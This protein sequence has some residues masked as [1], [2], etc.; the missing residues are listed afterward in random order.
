MEFLNFEPSE[1]IVLEES[2][3]FDET[4]QRP[5]KIRFFTLEEQEVDAYEKLLPKGKVTQFERNTLRDEMTRIHDLYTQFVVP[6]T[7]DYLLREPESSKHISWVYPVYAVDEYKT[8][9]FSSSWMPLYDNVRAP[10]FYSRMLT[11]LPSPFVESPEGI[12]TSVP[13]VTEFLNADGQKPR[14][15]LPTY[16]LTR[17][18]RHED[19]RIDIV[20]Q[21]VGGTEDVVSVVGYYLAKRPLEIPNPLEEHPFF[22]ANEARFLSTTSPLED[23]LPSL[24]AVLTH[25][26]PNTSDPYRAAGPYLKLY[27]V[28]LENIPWSMWKSKFPPTSVETMPRGKEAIPFPAHDESAPN[29]KIQ[30]VYGVPYAPGI[31]AREWLMRREDGGEF[32]VKA[33]LSKVIDNG[34]VESI[35]GV[36]LPTPAYPES[37][38]EECTLSELTF[39]DFV[40]KGLLRRS[41]KDIN[42]VPLE[43][44][45]QERARSGFVNRLPWK[46]T[47]GTELLDRHLKAL[48][49]YK[50]IEVVPS[51]EPVKPMTLSKGESILHQ[52]VIAIEEDP[53]RTEMDKLRDIQAIVKDQSLSN[54]IYTDG[55]GLF[56]VCSHTLAMLGGEF[57][58]DRAKFYETWTA[59]DG[60]YRVCKYC[61]QQVSSVDLVDR[62]EFTE[63]GFVIK[64]TEALET[65]EYHG[66]EIAGFVAGLQ[67]LKSLFDMD[68]PS[69][70]MIYML[71]S[72]LQVLPDAKS[73]Q[74]FLLIGRDIVRKIGAKDTDQIRRIKGTVGIAVTAVLL[75]AHVPALLPRRSFGS[76]P[77]LLSGYP[78]DEEE[79]G[80]QTIVDS[81]LM[82]IENTFRAFPT[83]LSGPT[84]QVI[85]AVLSGPQ[86]IRNNALVFIKKELLTQTS[87]KEMLAAAKSHQLP[88]VEV[89]QSHSALIP[90]VVPPERLDTVTGYEECPSLRPILA[91]DVA[92]PIVQAIVPLR[93]GIQA[94]R[95]A[96]SIVPTV[97]VRLN[98]ADVPKTVLQQKA[99]V[100]R[101]VRIKFPV[102]EGYR[103]NVLIA[104]RLADMFETPLPIRQ[105]NPL[106]KASELRDIGRSYV[107]E[108]LAAMQ[109]DPVKTAKLTEARTKDVALY[110]LL[111]DY[112]DEKAQATRLR[113]TERLNFVEEMS[114]RSDFE[115]EVI[116]DLLRIGLAPYIITNRDRDIFARQAEQLQTEIATRNDEEG[117]GQ[118]RDYTDQGDVEVPLVD[119]GDYGD[120][121]ALPTNDGRDYVQPDL[122]DDPERSI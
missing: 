117:V 115:R 56:V 46:E 42:C 91:S 27:D 111:A 110:T 81:L 95:S 2:I 97:S 116:G 60:G 118:A 109:Q 76:R 52:E 19:K 11:A 94:A 71:I 21:E 64:R 105:L 114:K 7:N 44:I 28:K 80:K 15:A 3:E 65:K 108:A 120:Y 43:F 83:T 6:T 84:Q 107:F 68:N 67:G 9:S 25:G 26:V 93:R 102:K 13:L 33:L 69:D 79:P 90:V 66:T 47:T 40:V 57:V 45:K 85:R 31:S 1:I 100:E 62:D 87:V 51:E 70:A 77:L 113:A 5:E 12:P 63:D 48:R 73:L 14:R 37:T 121:N 24:D 18:V 50:A 4:V 89:E 55:D 17:I 104:S 29:E 88:M 38:L 54:R 112:K 59:V 23:V 35:P 32:I 75:Q 119:G 74:P 30:S 106:Q 20:E 96:I 16:K 61:G 53:R 82:V 99:A 22:S 8:Y 49:R 39:S 98:V 122:N 101:S 34:S 92:P 78:R 41:G 103:T 72:L 36:D 10:N 58:R 86:A